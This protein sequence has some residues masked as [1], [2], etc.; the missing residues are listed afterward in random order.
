[1]I[2]R[3]QTQ[4]EPYSLVESCQTMGVSRSG[5]YEHQLKSS[6]AR[7]SQD[8]LI[9]AKLRQYFAQ[10]RRTYGCRRL[11]RMLEREG[12]R[13]GKNRINR[14]MDQLGLRAIQKRRFRPRTTQ[15]AHERPISPNRLKERAEPA[16]E[17]H[18]VWV[19]DITYLPTAEQGWLFLAVEMDLYSRTIVGWKLADSLAAPIVL[20]AFQRAVKAWSVPEIHHSDRGIQYAA[21]DFR[22][23]LKAYGVSSSMSAKANPY[24]NAV[25]E[26]FFAT[27]KTEC[28]QNQIPQDRSQTKRMLFDYIESFYNPSRLHSALDYRA[29][30]EFQAAHRAR[31][32]A[33]IAGEERAHCN[34]S[35]K[36]VTSQ[37][38][39]QGV[40]VR[41]GINGGDPSAQA[42]GAQA[43]YAG[44]DLEPLGRSAP[45][46]FNP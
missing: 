20:E 42:D 5:W 21:G 9:G 33:W 6:G 32:L 35:Q 14:L 23:E 3:L 31:V 40:Q 8:A 36:T 7:C 39:A 16:A 34:Q 25:M 26:S 13:C 15:S 27:L 24:D 4:G 38:E 46:V 19:S 43:V 28:F 45:S 1:V 29:P 17:P 22:R 2:R 44:F 41:N 18:E 12:I 11:Q 10:S 37:R 30:L